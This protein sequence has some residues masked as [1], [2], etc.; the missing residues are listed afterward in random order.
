M[1]L[2]E[3]LDS[4]DHLTPDDLERLKARIAAREQR[5][6]SPLSKDEWL[7]RIDKAVDSFWGDSSKEEIED[8]AA[9]MSKKFIDPRAWSDDNP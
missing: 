3:L 9:A 7:A 5:N 6:S 2:N 8:I 1:D 4:V